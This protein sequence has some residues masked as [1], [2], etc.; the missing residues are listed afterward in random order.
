VRFVLFVRFKQCL[1][2]TKFKYRLRL[3]G[4]VQGH[5][6]LGEQGV[7]PGL[8]HPVEPPEPPGVHA[9]CAGRSWS[10]SWIPTHWTRPCIVP[11]LY[12]CLDV[13]A[14]VSWQV[15]GALLWMA[16]CP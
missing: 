16:V 9:F 2:I 5:H 10:S 12:L 13:G 14:K 1:H 4:A 11:I 8:G 6:P 7:A 3:S 15:F